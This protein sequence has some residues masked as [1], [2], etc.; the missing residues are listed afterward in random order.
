M[1]LI[2]ICELIGNYKT[3]YIDKL[4][5][6][7]LDTNNKKICMDFFDD[8]DWY[9]I[10]SLDEYICDAYRFL[11]NNNELNENVLNIIK[12][13]KNI[14]NIFNDLNTDDYGMLVYRDM[15]NILN[16]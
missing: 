14:L 3:I 4:G 7:L 8:S 12:N 6:A 9:K 2:N 15:K 5:F 11:N 16:K 10:K 13:N 1:I